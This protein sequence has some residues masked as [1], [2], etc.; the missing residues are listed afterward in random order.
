MKTI[1][2]IIEQ[3][4]R[5]KP[6]AFDQ[7]VKLGWIAE[8]DGK[9]AAEVMLMCGGDLQ[10]F[11]YSYPAGLNAQPLV[12]FPYNDLYDHYLM[13][14]IDYHNGEYSKY[15]NSMEMFNARY[16]AFVR[17]FATTYEPAQGYYTGG[18]YGNV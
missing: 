17:W 5:V 1:L 3:V 18:G 13:A 11:C 7:Q 14:M 10:H 15:Q 9:I 6:N 12:E 16:S 2:Q 8:L 4:D